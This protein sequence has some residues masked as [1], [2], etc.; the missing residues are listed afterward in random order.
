MSD[1]VAVCD[2]TP[3]RARALASQFEVRAYTDFWPG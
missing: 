1:F 2:V 3:E